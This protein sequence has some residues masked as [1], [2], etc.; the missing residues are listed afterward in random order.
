MK[1]YKLAQDEILV[2]NE[3][4]GNW[5]IQ[6]NGMILDINPEAGFDMLAEYGL[7]NDPWWSDWDHLPR[8]DRRS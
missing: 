5:F 7:V 4:V 8:I 6:W 3:D 2:H 1:V